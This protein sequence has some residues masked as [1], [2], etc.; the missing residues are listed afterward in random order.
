ME[1]IF[2][3]PRNQQ[4]H[5]WVWKPGN[6]VGRRL[7]S[8]GTSNLSTPGSGLTVEVL[9]Q[10]RKSSCLGFSSVAPTP[11]RVDVAGRR[12]CLFPHHPP[13]GDVISRQP[14]AGVSPSSP[15]HSFSPPAWDRG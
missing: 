7:V 10:A 1:F 5:A 2:R 15:P 8:H 4:G 9:A 14:M 13:P 11:W 3:G 6:G 12:G